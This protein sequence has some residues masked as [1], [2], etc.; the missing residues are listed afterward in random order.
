MTKPIGEEGHI[1]VGDE[2]GHFGHQHPL[3]MKKIAKAPTSKR[4]HQSSVSVTNIQK[5]PPTLSHQHP[6]VTN[7]TVCW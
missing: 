3:S 4:C 7:I 1:D 2:F 5:L 6:N